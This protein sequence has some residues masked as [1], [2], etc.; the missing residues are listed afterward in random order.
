LIHACNVGS[1]G[2]EAITGQCFRTI[3]GNISY[4][5]VYLVNEAHAYLIY[6]IFFLFVDDI[7][8]PL[9]YSHLTRASIQPIQ[10][11]GRQKINLDK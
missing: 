5:H 3:R 9:T 4:L 2:S 6:Q 8:K 7:D 10:E 1:S 11:L